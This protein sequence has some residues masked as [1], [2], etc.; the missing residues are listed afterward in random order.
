MIGI[1]GRKFVATGSGTDPD[2]DPQLGNKIRIT[3]NYSTPVPVG[4]VGPS[5]EY[6]KL[7][8]D[9]EIL[10]NLEQDDSKLGFYTVTYPLFKGGFIEQIG[11]TSP[12]FFIDDG[13]G[14]PVH[15]RAAI[16]CFCINSFNGVDMLAGGYPDTIDYDMLTEIAGD[17]FGIMNHVYGESAPPDF[18][19]DRFEGMI[20]LNRKIYTKLKERGIEYKITTF[21]TPD[22]QEGF[23]STIMSGEIKIHVASSQGGMNSKDEYTFTSDNGLLSAV[24]WPKMGLARN[25]IGDTLS[26]SNW[27]LKKSFI[28]SAINPSTKLNPRILRMFFHGPGASNADQIQAFKLMMEYIKTQGGERLWPCSVH[29]FYDYK[30]VQHYA[31]KTEV[32]DGNKLT[33]LIDLDTIPD[34]IRWR[35]VSLLVNDGGLESIQVEGADSHSYNLSTGLINVFKKKTTFIDPAL[36]FVP[37]KIVSVVHSGNTAIITYDSPLAVNGLGTQV[38]GVAAYDIVG[39]TITGISGSGTTWTLTCSGTVSAGNKLWYR[40]QRGNAI[41]TNGHKVCSYKEFPIT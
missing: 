19:G 26:T 2:P 23:V 33:I 6:A 22:I 39:N 35:D 18:G 30:A 12:G 8:Y 41:G 27:E 38:S 31:T 14:N 7:K 15:W 11:E 10:F 25:F 13:C 28:D 37:P 32:I 40:M 34:E 3:V 9:K 16:A 17:D 5:A 21:V 29:E 1:K 24:G 36:D 4:P 20:R